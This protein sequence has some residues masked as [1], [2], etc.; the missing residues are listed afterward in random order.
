MSID[1]IMTDTEYADYS[2]KY[3]RSEIVLWI[4]LVYAV[5]QNL[6]EASIEAGPILLYS[7][8]ADEGDIF[9]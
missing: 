5:V 4:W 6:V 8:T 2:N 3:P 9:F 7:F 1:E